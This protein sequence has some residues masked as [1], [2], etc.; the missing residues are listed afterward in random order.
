MVFILPCA[1]VAIISV[2]TQIEAVLA[3]CTIIL[4]RRAN[5]TTLDFDSTG[6]VR[7]SDLIMYERHSF[8]GNPDGRRLQP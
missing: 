6:R 2:F 3:R 4:D 8:A 1:S 5:S 7:K